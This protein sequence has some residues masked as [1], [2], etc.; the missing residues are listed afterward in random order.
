[1][2]L[3]LHVQARFAE[4]G[5]EAP[6]ELRVTLEAADSETLVILGPSGSGKSLL[7]ETVAGLHPHTGSIR[8]R[9]RELSHLAPE[10]RGFGFVFQDYALFPHMS[11]RENIAFACP[12]PFAGER[13]ASLMDRLQVAHLSGR[14]PGRLSG[15]EKQRVALAR[16]LARRPRLLL[17]DE[18]LSSLDLPARESLRGDLMGILEGTTAV[19]VT[20]DRTEARLLGERVAVMREGEILQAGP[21]GEVFHRPASPFVARFT[22][23]NCLPLDQLPASPEGAPGKAE[24]LVLR[25][26]G[27]RLKGKGEGMP[28]RVLRILPEEASF[29]ISLGLGGHRLD[30]LVGTPPEEGAEV[31]VDWAKEEAWYL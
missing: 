19:Y 27:V 28:A 22:G 14:R 5:G 30:A 17:L 4:S 15:G 13:V 3:Q 25:P 18:P 6:L 24:Y 1:M 12:G 9:G 26:E 11:V 10:A 20:H 29:R 8:H 23:S 21:A 31:G 2:S 7:L 16:A